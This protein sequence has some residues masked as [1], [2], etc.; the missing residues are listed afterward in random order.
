ML[1]NIDTEVNVIKLF[2]FGQNIEDLFRVHYLYATLALHYTRLD[3]LT[4]DKRFSLFCDRIDDE[5]KKPPNIDNSRQCYKTFFF[6]S[7]EHAT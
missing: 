3:R 6:V 5:E 7:N 2:F 1:S 4:R